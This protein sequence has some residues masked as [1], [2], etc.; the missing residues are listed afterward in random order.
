M[1]IG[2][3][4]GRASRFSV[5]VSAAADYG[6]G[7]PAAREI[8][9]HIVSVIESQWLDACDAVGLSAANRNALWKRSFLNRS[10]F[11]E[12]WSRRA[13]RCTPGDDRLRC[14]HTHL[15]KVTGWSHAQ[16]TR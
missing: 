8:V 4:G 2:R 14:R 13:E 16:P 12:E 10:V 7:R 6:L 1:A 9:D 3:D 15:P 11:D 5:C